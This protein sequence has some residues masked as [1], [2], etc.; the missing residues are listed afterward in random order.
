VIAYLAHNL[1]RWSGAL[2]LPRRDHA[3]GPSL[4]RKLLLLP[5]RLTHSAR[6][7]TLHLPAR[8]P[9]QQGFIEALTRIP[10]LPTLT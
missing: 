7:W 10:A 2:G 3:G 4:R 9:W 6:R 5:G 8:W 1:V